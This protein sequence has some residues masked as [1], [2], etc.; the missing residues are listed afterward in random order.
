MR[1]IPVNT[2]HQQDFFPG[3]N[4]FASSLGNHGV[5]VVATTTL[6]LYFEEVCA[7]LAS[8]FFEPGEISVGTHVNIDHLAPAHGKLPVTVTCKLVRQSGRWLE[9]S[10]A[11][12]QD[13]LLVM[14]GE[15]HRAVMQ[16]KQFSLPKTR[17][18]TDTSEIE[19]WFDFHSPWCY[20]ASY[21][22]GDIAREFDANIKWR[23]VH[24]AN[25]MDAVDGRRPLQSNPRFLAWYAQ[26][27][28]DTA[29][30]LGVAFER[31]RDYP[32]RPSR[33]LRSAIFADDHGLIE[34][35]VKAVMQGYWSDQK[36]ISDLGWLATVAE[37]VGLD[38]EAVRKAAVDGSYK[39]RLNEN[40]AQAVDKNLFGLPSIVIDGKIFFGND[41]LNLVR[42]YLSGE[43]PMLETRKRPSC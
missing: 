27:Q 35:F 13:K 9:F 34:A 14:E 3:K 39:S 7:N 25:L 37:S 4:Q 31:H 26:D 29:T 5:D 19:F 20:F 41:R 10:L 12:H 6:I 30:M 1:D 32:K 43:I 18:R 33:A 21:Q 36:D 38:G 40:L 15:H 11:A 28:Q 2:I 8:P 24:L 16:R 42:H 17:G 22:I 23:P